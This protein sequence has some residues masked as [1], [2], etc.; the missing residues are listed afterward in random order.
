MDLLT[1]INKVLVRTGTVKSTNQLTTLTDSA[2]QMFIDTAK[3]NWN[4]VIDE[5][6][7][8]TTKPRPNSIKNSTVTLLEG[9]REYSLRSHLVT[10]RFDYHL[11]DETNNH[12]ITLVEDF[13]AQLVFGDIEQDDTG[14]PH[15]AT[16]NP[17]NGRLLFDRSPT[18]SDAG[19]IYKYRY[20]TDLELVDAT[21]EMPFSETV[22]RA[23]VPAVA[24]R[25][26]FEHQKTGSQEIFDKAM[27]QAARRLRQAPA[28]SSWLPRHS[29]HNAMDPFD[30]AIV[31]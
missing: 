14:L 15:M 7:S 20:E 17:E 25:W 11:I 4:E 24:E 18:A 8:L 31:Q 29:G 16:L 9:V 2:N 28:R 26:K 3:D 6:Y 23:L 1:G 21:D 5:L 12:T 13:H 10:L 27:A 30:A 22:S 19:K